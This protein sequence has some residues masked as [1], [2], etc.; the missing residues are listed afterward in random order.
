VS[1]F[2][3][4]GKALRSGVWLVALGISFGVQ[5]V[6]AEGPLATVNGAPLSSNDVLQRQRIGTLMQRVSLDRRQALNELISDRLKV[7]EAR[8]LGFRVGDDM[9][10]ESF[11]RLASANGGAVPF[12]Q[13]L[14]RGGINPEALKSKLRADIAWELVMRSAARD[15]TRLSNTEITAALSQKQAEGQTV[16]TDF[17]LQSVV[18]IVPGGGGSGAR[19]I[20]KARAARKGFS[21]CASGFDALRGTLDVA[22]KPPVTRSSSDLPPE[23][24]ALLNKTPIGKLTE[25]YPSPEGIEMVAVCGRRD[26]Q[27]LAGARERID[28]DA[29]SKAL[30]ARAAAMLEALRKKA[31]IE[32]RR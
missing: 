28:Q 26:R 29:S 15:V 19:E 17:D 22:V 11:G 14:R 18:F 6:R 4:A 10:D 2:I 24:L 27:D 20:A 32:Y 7:Q 16:V 1:L 21:G 5:T 25:P 31:V 3:L 23:I 8:R 13:N 9:V 30:E 12:T